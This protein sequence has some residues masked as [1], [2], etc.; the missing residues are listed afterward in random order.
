MSHSYKG[1][2]GVF[3]LLAGSLLLA[4]CLHQPQGRLERENL[5]IAWIPKALDN[6]VFELGRQG[7]LKKASELSAAGPV[8]V[9]I[10]YVGSVSADP[11]E[12]VRVLEDVIA[13]RVDAIAVSCIDPTACTDPI[14][15]AVKA[16]IPVMTWDS[17]APQ[18]NRFT[19]LGIDNY[20][21][22]WRAGE[23]LV[24]EMGVRGEVAILTGVPG[25]FNL[26]E[27]IRGFR[28]H[29]QAYPDIQVVATVFTYEDINRGVQAVEETLQ[30]HPDL[31]GWF[32]VGMWPL[33]A[34]KGSMPLWEDAAKN[35]GLVTIAFD[36]L[37]LELRLL[38]EGYLS[39][40][41]G[42]KY[43]SWGYDTVQIIY[44]YV[45]EG[46]PSP[47]IVHSGMDIVTRENVDAMLKAWESKDFSTPFDFTSPKL[48]P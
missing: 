39:G 26:E 28:D 17:D 4:A 36:T 3:F 43:W 29:I 32:F 35:R 11:A 34:E 21:A 18:S 25:A 38:K 45:L 7:A 15:Q 27:R 19:F 48:E 40:L 9:E 31:N 24:K 33:F 44:D 23:L 41:I 8:E 10:L 16:G 14:N 5:T 1:F 12:Q 6:P 37:P 30:A 20:Y 13:S 46:K 47:F 2:A 22:G 42:Q